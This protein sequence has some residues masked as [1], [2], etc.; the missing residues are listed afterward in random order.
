[1]SDD[2]PAT[3]EVYRVVYFGERNHNA[4]CFKPPEAGRTFT[5]LLVI[6]DDTGATS[7]LGD[8]EEPIPHRE[9]EGAEDFSSETHG[10]TWHYAK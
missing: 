3:T 6:D 7:Y 5:R 4:L 8:E 9:L 1:M 10:H 2:L